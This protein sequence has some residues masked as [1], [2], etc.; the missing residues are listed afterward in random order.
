MQDR[1]FS[2]CQSDSWDEDRFIDYAMSVIVMVPSRCSRWLKPVHRRILYGNEWTRCYTRQTSQKSARITGDV[3]G[4]YHHMVIRLPGHGSY[5]PVVE[6]PLHACCWWAWKTLA[7]RTVRCC[8][9]AR[10]TEARTSKIRFE[11]LRDINK[12]RWFR[13]TTTML[14]NVNL[15]LAS[16]FSKPFCHRIT[17]IAVDGNHIPP[18]NLG[19]TIDE[20][21]GDVT[22]EVTT[23]GLDGSLAWS[24]FQLVPLSWENQVSIRLMRLVKVPLPSFSYRD[25]NH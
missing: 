2:E 18:H 5:G 4:K 8:R 6:L 16:S 13:R 15:G 11:M 17:G 24:R 21:V 7:P 25:G 22:S 19:E 23:K 3:M 9:A 12:H 1:K 14:T 20:E 10:H